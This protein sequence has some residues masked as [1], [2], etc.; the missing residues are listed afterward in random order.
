MVVQSVIRSFY[1]Q[2]LSPLFTPTGEDV[3]I[4]ESFLN[5]VGKLTGFCLVAVSGKC[6]RVISG[7][8][9]RTWQLCWR[10]VGPGCFSFDVQTENKL[11]VAI[12]VFSK[13]LLRSKPTQVSTCLRRRDSTLLC[14][15]NDK[16]YVSAYLIL[17][18]SVS[19]FPLFSDQTPHLLRNVSFVRDYRKYSVIKTSSEAASHNPSLCLQTQILTEAAVSCHINVG[20]ISN[21]RLQ[22]Q[23][24]WIVPLISVFSITL[25]LSQFLPHPLDLSVSADVSV[26]LFGCLD[27]E[28]LCWW[29]NRLEQRTDSWGNAGRLPWWKKKNKC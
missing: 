9:C 15:C 24:W 16:M 20:Y 4:P 29:W 12:S 2:V 27:G 26:C 7:Q 11:A 5:S 8:L 22:V 21:W 17:H 19:L 13:R 25:R 10:S 28:P 3:L 23:I 6:F 14:F 1:L 18:D